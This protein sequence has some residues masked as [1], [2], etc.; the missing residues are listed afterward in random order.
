MRTTV[1][2]TSIRRGVLAAGLAL[3]VGAMTGSAFAAGTLYHWKTEDGTWAFADDLKRVPERYR[4]Q[5]E[6]R[7]LESVKDYPRY[8]ATDPKAQATYREGLARR[9]EATRQVAE[10]PAVT[11][12]AGGGNDGGLR[13]GADGQLGLD[14]S[15]GFEHEP[16]VIE[17]VRVRPKGKI[18]TRHDQVIRQGDRVLLILKGRGRDTNVNHDIRREDY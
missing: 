3:A 9:V 18:T 7:A 6:T 14:F 17:K 1:K 2:W 11:P 8:T 5:V 16:I 4:E 12:P 10:S 13:L 15:H